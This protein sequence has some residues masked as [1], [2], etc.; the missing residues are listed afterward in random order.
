M[1]FAANERE[2][3]HA[4][5]RGGTSAHVPLDALIETAER[6]YSI[7]LRDD[8]TPEELYHRHW[9]SALLNRVLHRV[10]D[11]FVK[12]GKGELFESLKT[13][14]TGHEGESGYSEVAAR[15]EMSEG[16][17][18]V[19]VHR[20]RR[21]YRDVLHEEIAHTVATADEA[22]QEIRDLLGVVRLQPRGG[23]AV[24]KLGVHITNSR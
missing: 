20:L 21:R 14:L 4:A 12:A 2:R 13:Y 16:A 8:L 15:L 22:D 7:E 23:L 3:A 17:L 10:R 11:E 1:N 18:K 9:V 19:A 24:R 6:R 5:R